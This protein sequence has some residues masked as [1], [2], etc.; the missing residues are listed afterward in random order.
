MTDSEPSLAIGSITISADGK[1]I[2]AGTGEPNHSGDSYSGAGLLKST[3]GGKTWAVYGE[4]TFKGSAISGVIVNPSNPNRLL[5]STTRGVCCKGFFTDSNQ[6]AYGVYLSTDGGSTWTPTLVSHSLEVSFSELVVN[7]TNS[8][9]VYAAGFNGTVW[10]STDDGSSW[11]ILLHLTST[12]CMTGVGC[13]A[14]IA[15]TAAKPGSVYAAFSDT[16]GNLYGIYRDD[17]STGQI[18][19]L[20]SPPNPAT[21]ITP[22]NGQCDYD[23]LIAADPSNANVLYFGGVDLFLSTDGGAS[24]TDLGGFSP[25][26]LHPD[27]HAFAFLPSTSSTIY[28][29]NDGGIWESADRGTTWTDLNAGLGLT[30]FYS[31]AGTP[32]TFLIGGAQDNGCDK[33]TGSS[34]WPQVGGG[35]GGWSGVESTNPSIAYC[36]YVNLDFRKST[37]GGNTFQDAVNGINQNDNSEFVA[38]VAQDPSTPGTLYIG[39]T[40]VYKTTDF[41]TTW[42][43]VSGPLGGAVISVLAVAPS[44]SSTVYLGDASGEIKVSNDGG[45]TWRL[46]GT[47][48]GFPVSG[49]AVDP[50]N[51]NLVYV[52]AAYQTTLH[53][54]VLQSGAWQGAVL[55]AAPDRINVVRIDKAGNLYVGTDHGT[56]YSTDS[57]ATWA[58]PGTGLPNIAVFDLEITSSNQLIAAT[59]G[60]GVWM[61]TPTPPTTV[62]ITASF[63]VSGGGSGYSAPVL[64]YTIGGAQQTA[65]LSNTPTSYSA[66][67]GSSWSIND[68]LTGS[69]STVRWQTNQATS[70]TATSSVTTALVYYHQ[71]S[72]TYGFNIVGGGTGYSSPAVNYT[73]FGIITSTTTGTAVWGDASSTYSYPAQLSGS[74]ANQRWATSTKAGTIT[75]AG[76]V[77]VPFYHQYLLSFDYAI[78]GSGLPS[79]PTLSSLSFGSAFTQ[80][81]TSTLQQVWVDAGQTYSATNPLAGSTA[82]ERW[83]SPS[84]NGTVS[85]AATIPLSYYHQYALTVTELMTTTSWYNEGALASVNI[86][87][88]LGR[89]DGAGFRAASASLDGGPSQAFPLTLS[90]VPFSITMSQPHTLAVSLVRQYQVSLDSVA[91]QAL[92]SITQP[93]IKGDVYWYDEGTPVSLALN[94]VWGRASGS[95]NRLTAYSVNGGSSTAVATTGTVSAFST[96][97]ISSPQSVT[98]TS[99]TQYQLSM[100]TGSVSSVTPPKISGDAGWYDSGASVTVNYSNV[101]NVVSQKSRIS[102]TGYSVDGGSVTSVPEA[103]SGTFSVS[104]TMNSPH[105]IDVKSVTQYYTAFT[106]TN[107]SG[108]MAIT[109][110]D[111][112]VSVRGQTQDV[113]GFSTWLDN[114]TSFT[115]AKVTYEGVDVK[116]SGTSQ[117]SVT[118][119]NSVAIKAR[120]YDATLKV[121]DSL[122]LAVSGAQVKMTLA[123]GAVL[124]GTTGG[125]GT[126]TAPSIPLG[127]FTATV[128]SLGF[129]A[130]VTGD[131]STQSV[132]PASVLL[133]TTSLG[134]VVAAVVVVVGLAVFLLRRKSGRAARPA[135]STPAP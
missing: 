98:A 3:D 31:I 113:P 58:T 105:T 135:G 71:F 44:S 91:T 127:T 102:A 119:P 69:S 72:V 16:A 34:S 126:F 83:Y 14:T 37:D 104:L 28:E 89:A 125:D 131:A 8:N 121:A 122:G 5:V 101:W 23:L 81:L 128:S 109:P 129:S 115:L 17:L 93:T 74:S 62:K 40:H 107:A 110:S 41:A 11:S 84:A 80:P 25:G 54:F 26:S 118:G 88:T 76:T 4:S 18:V 86:T 51:A 95:G 92:S 21:G 56:Y 99:V 12:N 50:S 52:A 68:P 65:V 38:P 53:K 90:S 132:T 64:T 106:F 67:P 46:V 39:G 87:T 48:T 45:T 130:Q 49:L 55:S 22:C 59:H 77:T 61:V 97:S 94:G 30:Q 43:D 13:R 19:A 60:R 24:W 9:T 133:S 66:D 63:S 96:N 124:S 103:G 100:P 36:N 32:S 47:I 57:G 78:V 116:P 114:G 33:Y 73:Q 108:S 27:Q 2:Y 134:I 79:A 112:Q 117:Y 70:G 10:R 15:T 35:D 20:N 29:G 75:A 85:G 123:N 82:E 6:S 7:A 120:V 111:L 42:N 1:T